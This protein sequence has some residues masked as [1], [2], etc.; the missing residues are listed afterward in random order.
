M[1]K[2]SAKNL[3]AMIGVIA[4][5]SLTACGRKLDWTQDAPLH[6]ART[7]VVERRSEFGSSFPGNSGLE[8]GQTLTFRHPD[9]GERITWRIPEG[10]QPVMI[11]FDRGVPYYVLTEYT[12]ADYNQWGCPNPPYLVYRY[13]Q[14]KWMRIAFE[15]LPE[16]FLNRN[17]L[18]MSKEI[19]GL[20]D[21]GH[22]SAYGLENHWNGYPKTM[23]IRQISRKKINPIVKGCWESTLHKQGR[24][25]EIDNRR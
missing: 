23:N 13:E 14:G 12:V 7:L 10:L 9:T 2:R 6:D 24:Q 1:N 21:G 25:S 17:L 22:V 15:A 16:P 20:K 3:I 5:F 19:R 18:E 4:G 11:D 8:I